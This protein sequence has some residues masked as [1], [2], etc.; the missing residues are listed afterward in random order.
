MYFHHSDNNLPSV[1]T[2]E[3]TPEKVFESV[4]DPRRVVSISGAE[5]GDDT[6]KWHH[7]FH[8][9]GDLSEVKATNPFEGESPYRGMGS[10]EF[11]PYEKIKGEPN[12]HSPEEGELNPSEDFPS[13]WD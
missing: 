10:N 9:P 3:L 11:A 1:P 7:G 2:Q 8:Y 12:W 4:A 13:S 6:P 5:N